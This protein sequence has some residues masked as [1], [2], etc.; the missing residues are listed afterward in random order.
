VPDE[1]KKLLAQ[2]VKAKRFFDSLS[3]TNRKEYAVW[4]SSAKKEET[5]EKRLNETLQKLL[6]GLKNPSQKEIIPS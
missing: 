6:K 2:N 1:L 3:Y 5:R 4:I